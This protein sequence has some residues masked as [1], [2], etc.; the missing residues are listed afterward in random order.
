MPQSPGDG[1]REWVVDSREWA[2]KNCLL[3]T[4]P[5]P[6][7]TA[8]FD[9]IKDVDTLF[10]PDYR[11]FQ[12][13]YKIFVGPDLPE[14]L[15]RLCVDEVFVVFFEFLFE[16]FGEKRE[17]AFGNASQ[18]LALKGIVVYLIKV[19]AHMIYPCRGA[20]KLARWDRRPY[21]SAPQHFLCFNTL[22]QGQESLRPTALFSCCSFC[23]ALASSNTLTKNGRLCTKK[24]L[25]PSHK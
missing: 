3:P 13:G 14:M 15:E 25:N 19:H 9:S 17:L 6:L 20:R 10:R 4:T 21:K 11:F 12:H 23:L 24:L 5:Y 22:P 16:A 7:A 8:L 2:V 18:H 1:N